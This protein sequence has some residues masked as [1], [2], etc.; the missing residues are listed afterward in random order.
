M[1]WGEEKRVVASD[2]SRGS[3]SISLVL[4]LARSSSTRRQR[5][6]YIAL[7]SQRERVNTRRLR[8]RCFGRGCA[9]QR[10]N[11]DFNWLGGCCCFSA[12]MSVVD[13]VIGYK[14][15]EEEDFYALLGC[16]ESSSVSYFLFIYLG[17]DYSR[18][19]LIFPKDCLLAV[20]CDLFFIRR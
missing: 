14:P 15:S 11:R 6:H 2:I 16:D 7:L 12:K 17:W 19:V 20:S 3:V 13:D 4:D 10:R 8:N 18:G 1:G 5:V 9:F